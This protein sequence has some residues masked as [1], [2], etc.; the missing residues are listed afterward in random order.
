MDRDEILVNQLFA[1]TY[2]DEGMNIGHEVINLFRDDNGENYIYITPGGSVD[3]KAHPV[4][5]VI[6]VRSIKGKTTVE[7]IAKAEELTEP[8]LLPSEI[9][10]AGISIEQV[11]SGNIY[12]GETNAGR[13]FTFKAGK[14]RVPKAGRRIILTLDDDFESDDDSIYLVKLHSN[15]KVITPQS[16]RKYYSL[17]EDPDAYLGLQELLEDDGCWEPNNTTQKLIADNTMRVLGPTFLEI[18]RKDN[19]ELTFSNLLGYYFQYNKTVFQKFVKEVLGVDDFSLCFDVVRESNENIDLW[20]EGDRHVL[21]IENKIKSGVNGLKDDN[22]SQLNKYQEYTEERI[23]DAKDV[24]YKKESHYFIFTPDY[25]RL[26]IT[27][28]RLKKPYKIV[29]YSEIY[30]FFCKNAVNFVGEKYFAD[31]LRALQKHTM[32]L[33]ELNFSIMRSRF[34][35]KINRMK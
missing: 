11:F 20:I 6:F 17:Q 4:K 22:Y 35:E 33:S 29:N 18:I 28:Y 3:I 25:N 2:L 9:K 26:D 23:A 8:E 34:L 30:R 24:E 13:C 19:D 16:A 5:S 1:G 14:M 7:V 31:F 32:S 21:V 27:K 12:H 10:Y 15:F